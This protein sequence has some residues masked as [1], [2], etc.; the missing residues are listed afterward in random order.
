VGGFGRGGKTP[1]RQFIER[2][3]VMTPPLH[4]PECVQFVR[5]TAVQTAAH[6]IT[7]CVL[8]ALLGSDADPVARVEPVI[9]RRQGS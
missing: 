3:I 7:T 9:Q 1:A 8:V 4:E 2:T 5:R 6:D